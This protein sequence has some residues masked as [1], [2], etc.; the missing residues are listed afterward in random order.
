LSTSLNV[1]EDEAVNS[2]FEFRDNIID[3]PD[4]CDVQSRDKHAGCRSID[5]EPI[6]HPA[7]AFQPVRELSSIK[8][9]PFRVVA[10]GRR[11]KRRR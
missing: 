2:G 11:I 7:R 5:L 6:V 9:I 8:R 4:I 10:I 3:A 1:Y